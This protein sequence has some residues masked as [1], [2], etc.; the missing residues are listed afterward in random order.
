[1]QPKPP[2]LRAQGHDGKLQDGVAAQ[3]SSPEQATAA[4][5]RQPNVT[6]PSE[7]PQKQQLH[8]SQNTGSRSEAASADHQDASMRKTVPTSADELAKAQQQKAVQAAVAAYIARRAGGEVGN[9]GYDWRWNEKAKSYQLF[10]RENNELLY[11]NQ[12]L[13]QARDTR[14]SDSVVVQQS[15]FSDPARDEL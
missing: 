1:M 9:P 10:A 11:T 8:T 15:S 12:A 4:S 2:L 3:H 13:E 6:A 7:A 5:A 14:T